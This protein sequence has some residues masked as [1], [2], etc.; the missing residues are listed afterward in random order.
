[1]MC[2]VGRADRALRVVVGAA[3]LGSYFVISVP[4][5]RIGL[6]GFLPIGTALVGW[7]PAL[8]ALRLRT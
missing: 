3:L 2:N 8:F 6:I 1:M 5:N 4:A 7:C